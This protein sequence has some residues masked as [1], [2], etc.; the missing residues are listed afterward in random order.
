MYDSFI[1]KIETATKEYMQPNPHKR[2]T[3][4]WKTSYLRVAGQDT[5]SARY[6]QVEASL[7]YRFT[8][9][10]VELYGLRDPTPYEWSLKTLGESFEH[11]SE[12]KDVL[13]DELRKTFLHP[14]SSMQGEIRE[15]LD[16]LKKFDKRRL[17]YDFNR[18][19]KEKVSA[20]DLETSRYKYE[21]CRRDCY[22]KMMK[23]TEEESEHVSVLYNLV[24]SLQN[25]HRMCHDVMSDAVTSIDEK[26]KEAT[27][28]KTTN[29]KHNLKL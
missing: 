21:S 7:A 10:S 6:P 17:E 3:T 5:D 19:H 2:T 27:I 12:N 8:K 26:M 23:F 13:E 15:I 16:E 18:N 25:H 9:F 29:N 11:L 4:T 14:L 20:V 1:E 28:T 22:M 24:R